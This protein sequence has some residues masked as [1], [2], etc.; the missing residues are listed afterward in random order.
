MYSDTLKQRFYN[1]KY[2]GELKDANAVRQ[3][4]NMKCGDIMKLFLKIDDNGIIQKAQFL[5]YGCMAAIA[6][7]DMLCEMLIGTH[8]DKA[9]KLT[10]QELADKL[11]KMPNAKFHCSILG[12]FALKNA[13]R[14]YKE[15][16]NQ[17]Q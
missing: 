3:E 2:A 11:G 17:T 4:G 10:P 9:E 15:K 5:T 8:I 7:T 16:A 14:S 13:I 1:T 12:T 6:S